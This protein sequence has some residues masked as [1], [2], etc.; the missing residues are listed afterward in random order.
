M[1]SFA[2]LCNCYVNIIK[3]IAYFD[4]KFLK[5][6]KDELQIIFMHNKTIVG[7]KA[8][9]INEDLFTL[10]EEK[11]VLQ[12]AAYGFKTITNINAARFHKFCDSYKAYNQKELVKKM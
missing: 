3:N 9:L 6:Y 5:N 12:N 7:P 4:N 8:Y 2:S 10:I 11:G 1:T